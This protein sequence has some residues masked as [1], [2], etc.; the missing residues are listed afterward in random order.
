M[1]YP[2][3]YLVCGSSNHGYFFLTLKKNASKRCRWDMMF[4]IGFWRKA[5]IKLKASSAWWSV[6]SPVVC[7]SFYQVRLHRTKYIDPTT[8]IPSLVM[9]LSSANGLWKE[10][11][12]D[13]CNLTSAAVTW[14]FYC[15]FPLLMNHHIPERATPPGWAP[16]W[17]IQTT[18]T[19][20]SEPTHTMNRK[21][22]SFISDTDIWGWFATAE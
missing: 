20:N 16:E 3:S 1:H 6:L 22:T 17:R 14:C 2:K 7:C 18:D 8:L 9:W 10:V 19:A 5:F 12:Y 11:T 15:P 4:A 13:T 21:S